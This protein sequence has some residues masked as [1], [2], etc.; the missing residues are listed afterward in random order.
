MAAII[1]ALCALTCLACAV[2]LLR[3]FAENRGQLLLWSGLCFVGLTAGNILLVL[4]R[5][6]LP[7]V[8]L[9]TARLATAFFS[10]LLMLFGLIWEHE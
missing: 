1:Y 9:S 3:A 8:D 4:D 6:F 5:V 7:M 2:L 10:L